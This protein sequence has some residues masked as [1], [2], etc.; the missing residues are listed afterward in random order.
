MA[1]VYG[2]L[3]ILLMVAAAITYVDRSATARFEADALATAIRVKDQSTKAVLERS[4]LE[5]ATIRRSEIRQA[6][7]LVFY[8]NR[9]MS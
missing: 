4:E 7:R 8:D 5:V 2:I 3:A 6:P 1:A 9:R